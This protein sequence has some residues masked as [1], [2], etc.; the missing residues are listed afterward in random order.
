MSEHGGKRPG[1]G[2]KRQFSERDRHDIG[3]DCDSRHWALAGAKVAVAAPAP[4]QRGRIPL[5][6]P[7]GYRADIISDVAADWGTTERM[8]T[9]CWVEYRARKRA[10]NQLPNIVS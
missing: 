10:G 2:R 8:V 4:K 9:T 5:R 6:R 7:K 1:A 3:E